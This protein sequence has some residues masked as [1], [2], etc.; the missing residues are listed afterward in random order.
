MLGFGTNK[1]LVAPSFNS[2]F[3]MR[4]SLPKQM[5][6]QQQDSFNSLFEMRTDSNRWSSYS[7]RNRLSILYLRCLLHLPHT[8]LAKML[9]TLSILYLR[10]AE[11]R[12]GAGN[13]REV[14][15]NSLF[16]MLDA[17]TQGQR[18]REEQQLSILYLRCGQAHRDAITDVGKRD[19]QFSI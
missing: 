14:A 7:A 9:I 10:C 12:N 8:A 6:L 19:F 2:L 13:R 4:R 3:E 11:V 5:P 17:E 18:E 15:F 1:S 16:E